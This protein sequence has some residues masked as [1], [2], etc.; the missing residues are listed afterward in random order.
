MLAPGRA[1]L[2]QE[3]PGLGYRGFRYVLDGVAWR[4]FAGS[5][6]S[7]EAVLADP[8]RQVERVL[9][10]ELPQEFAVLRPRLLREIL[11]L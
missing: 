7:P 5:V 6:A 11:D 3:L 2:A 8:Q 9:V 4:A 1:G 10:D